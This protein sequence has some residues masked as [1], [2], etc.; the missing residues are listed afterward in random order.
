MAE[1]QR[2]LAELEELARRE[3]GAVGQTLK[4]RLPGDVGFC[5]FAFT[6]GEGPGWMTYV[7]N[8]ERA[9]M[10]EALREFLDNAALPTPV[11]ARIEA[12]ASRLT[13]ELHGARLDRRI[14]RDQQRVYAA[15]LAEMT[16]A[17]SRA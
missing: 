13:S 6:M 11:D 4:K 10:V 17:V 2:S 1:S 7:S 9:S 3:V 16:A 8:A 12:L 14:T 15:A 5:L